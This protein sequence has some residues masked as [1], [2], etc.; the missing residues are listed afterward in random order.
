MGCIP[1]DRNVTIAQI[2][3]K[4]FHTAPAKSAGIKDLSSI[5]SEQKTGVLVLVRV[6]QGNHI[7]DI[8]QLLGKANAVKY[9]DT[10]KSCLT[11]K[12]IERYS[13][14]KL[15]SNSKTMRGHQTIGDV[16]ASKWVIIV[17]ITAKTFD[18]LAHKGSYT[19]HKSI[20]D[21]LLRGPSIRIQAIQ[22]RQ[23]QN[24]YSMIQ[25]PPLVADAPEAINVVEYAGKL[26][27]AITQ[28][29]IKIVNEHNPSNLYTLRSLVVHPKLEKV[30]NKT[31]TANLREIQEEKNLDIQAELYISASVDLALIIENFR[32][33]V[34]NEFNG[35]RISKMVFKEKEGS[36]L[37]N[38]LIATITPIY[39]KV[40]TEILSG[41]TNIF[42]NIREKYNKLNTTK[43]ITY[44]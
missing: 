20:V 33:S 27:D 7:Y 17:Q 15:L 3:N 8:S 23:C 1:R 10:D 26:N 30:I 12:T 25:P 28:K 2:I 16:K 5:A 36:T 41:K 11:L 22:Q 44:K 19:I 40:L 38:Y 32:I 9:Q 31:I 34:G 18:I 14:I 29:F 13:T 6:E 42:A 43:V 37:N 39:L 4:C 35:L 21:K 24:I